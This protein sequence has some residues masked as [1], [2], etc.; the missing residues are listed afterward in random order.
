[1]LAGCVGLQLV[2]KHGAPTLNTGGEAAANIG[3]MISIY[4]YA[5]TDK[6]GAAEPSQ[7]QQQQ[8]QEGP[9]ASAPYDPDP[10]RPNAPPPTTS[11]PST[12]QPAPS[13]PQPEV[14]E[15]VVVALLSEPSLA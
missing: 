1:M 12:S 3:N 5:G 14:G 4:G 11:A 10:W 8:Q 13:K 2:P 15:V 9:A 6:N 7:Q